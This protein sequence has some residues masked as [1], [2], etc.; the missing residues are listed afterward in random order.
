MIVGH[1]SSL[2]GKLLPPPHKSFFPSILKITV[3]QKLL[4]LTVSAFLEVGLL[5]TTFPQVQATPKEANQKEI[6][7]SA[8]QVSR[9]LHQLGETGGVKLT[10]EK[11]ISDQIILVYA[12]EVSLKD[13][14][15]KVAFA[16]Y[17]DWERRNDRFVLR[18]TEEK[19]EIL[20]KL[21]QEQRE[22]SLKTVLDK[23]RKELAS[24]G[25][26]Q[27]W[28]DETLRSL[29]HHAENLSSLKTFPTKILLAKTLLRLGHSELATLPYHYV[30]TYSDYPTPAQRPLPTGFSEDLKR[31]VQANE[32]LI[33]TFPPSSQ[34]E[35]PPSEA[36]RLLLREATLSPSVEKNSPLCPFRA[37]PTLGILSPL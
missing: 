7:I 4:L 2:C 17:A 31:Y 21:D 36:L 12:K 16:L 32:L 26:P 10:A 8:S 24:V 19:K 28:V 27:H 13:V 3:V 33:Q 25:E 6:N 22:N 34:E 15:E 18:R 9:V 29:P 5:G 20:A 35:P 30:V 1:K 23:V 14:L 11:P 37:P